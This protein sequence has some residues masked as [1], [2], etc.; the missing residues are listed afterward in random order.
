MSMADRRPTAAALPRS[1][2]ILLRAAPGGTVSGSDRFW[3]T[4][5][6]SYD[7]EDSCSTM[8]RPIPIRASRGG[9]FVLPFFWTMRKVA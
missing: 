9:F 6:S 5:L 2:R 1:V 7:G 3:P 8:L 4:V